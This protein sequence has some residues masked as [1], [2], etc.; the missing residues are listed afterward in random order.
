[1]HLTAIPLTPQLIKV[2]KLTTILLLAALLQVSA[3]GLTQEVSMRLSNTTIEKAFKEIEKQTGYTFIYTKE[4]V[5]TAKPVT[6]S[7]EKQQLETVLKQIFE[8]QQLTYSIAGKY[9]SVKMKT[10]VAESIQ[11]A[12]E[13]TPPPVVRGRITNEKGEAVAGVN[14]SIKGDKLIGVTNDNGEFTLLNVPNDAVLVFSAVT[15]ETFETKLNG[16]TDLALS[17]KTKVSQL[18]E[19]VVNKGYYSEKKKNSVGNV[20]T[21]SSK[22][23][24]KQPV[25]NPLLALQGLSPGV[26]I[27]QKSGVS[28]AGVVVR[29]RG[30]NSVNAGLDPLYII[31]GVP[32]QSQNLPGLG[33]NIL[34]NSGQDGITSTLDQRVISG[35]PLSFINP[36]DIESIEILK[37]ADATAIYGSRAANGAILINTKKGKAGETKVN[38]NFSE[39]WGTITRKVD[40]LDR[41]QYLDMRYE[42]FRNDGV[43]INSSSNYDLRFWDTTRNVDW[44]NELIGGTARRKDIQGSISG[45]NSSIQYLISGQY[46]RESTVFPGDFADKRGGLHF[47]INSV[48]KNGRF[49]TSLSGSYMSDDNRLM[50]S[51]LTSAAVS[52]APVAPALLNADG[53]INWAVNPAGVATYFNN[54]LTFYNERKYRNQTTNLTSNLLL[55]YSF[56]NGL[57]LRSSFGYS[58]TQSNEITTNPLTAVSPTDR[59]SRTR[60]ASYSDNAIKNWIIEPQLNYS[61]KIGK[62]RFEGLIGVSIQKRLSNGLLQDGEGFASDLLLEDIKSAPTVKINTTTVTEYAYSALYGRLNYNHDNKYIINVTARRDGSSRFSPE[63]RFQLFGSVGAGWIFSNEDFVKKHLSF[64]SFG[65]IRASYGMTGNDQI[66]DYYYLDLYSSSSYAVPYQGVVGLGVTRL[67]NPALEWEQTNKGEIGVELGFLNDRFNIGFSY[68]NNRSSNQLTGYRLSLNTG[69]GNITAN[70]DALIENSGV[71]LVINSVNIRSKKFAWTSS[72]NISSIKNKLLRF[73]SKTQ[74]D[75]RYLGN[76]LNAVLI[77]RYAGVDPAT[78]RSSF[79]N[80]SGVPVLRVTTATDLFLQDTDPSYFGG[81]QN[82]FSYNGFELSFLFQ[83]VKQIGRNNLFGSSTT[84]PGWNNGGLGNQPVWVLQGRWQNPGDIATRQ[85]LTQDV[86]NVTLQTARSAAMGSDAGYSDASYVRLKN[87]SLSYQIGEKLLRKAKITNCR[88]S[89][90]A[91]NLF[92]LTRYFGSDPETKSLSTLPPLRMITAGIQLTL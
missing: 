67:Y 92:V 57:E 55:S 47:N 54:P 46:T 91:Q 41:R 56:G 7:A 73:G 12:P 32:F 30:R 79:L 85:P 81:F 23:I 49:K 5:S 42:A 84:V 4:R 28:G 63:S 13:A 15:I 68:F 89:V 16:R 24:E 2:M 71:E 90:N 34:G 75:A 35:N 87:I 78:G 83:F 29:I 31:D 25:Q 21:I 17:S 43:N 38:I 22:D 52:L 39:G 18:E 26:E 9:I 1:M 76:S 59:P 10:T 8:G 62:G 14:I 86:N 48:S 6:I 82:N 80:V 53:T 66:Q 33:N 60:S 64:L 58:N 45:G 20:V 37:D 69:F 72:F 65:K 40:L 74:L 88:L 19:I 77:S 36:S 61:R 51:D 27:T 44:Q 3:K 70:N 50:S 11:P